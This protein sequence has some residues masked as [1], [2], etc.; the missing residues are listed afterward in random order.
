MN[1]K[2]IK[3]FSYEAPA[4]LIHEKIMHEAYNINKDEIFRKTPPNSRHVLPSILAS[5]IPTT[6][7]KPC[8]QTKE[9]RLNNTQFIT[10][11]RRCHRMQ[12]IK[13]NEELICKCGKTVDKYGDHIF[14][15][16]HHSKTKL[17]NHIRNTIHYLTQTIGIHGNFIKTKDSCKIEEGGL[18]PN[19]PS[20]RPGDI[21]IHENKLNT[22]QYTDFKE[23]IIAIDCTINEK[24][25][26]RMKHPND[27]KTATSNH[28]EHHLNIEAKKYNRPNQ[29]IGQ[30][31]ISGESIIHELNKQ[32]ITLKAFTI[33][34]FGTLGP[35]AESYFYNVKETKTIE[36][37][38]TI[39]KISIPARKANQKNKE[40]KI[41]KALFKKAN[42]GWHLTNKE[43]WFGSTYQTTVPSTWGNL[44][45]HVNINHAIIK[46]ISNALDKL[47]N[48]NKEETENKLYKIIGNQSLNH[49]NKNE[50]HYKKNKVKKKQNQ[51]NSKNHDDQSY[52][53]F[54]QVYDVSNIQKIPTYENTHSIPRKTGT[55][56]NS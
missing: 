42:E 14:S 13:T 7:L 37:E 56:L 29:K 45:L 46:H 35:Q 4:H 54:M 52:D 40:E 36:N 53:N 5:K 26:E 27:L 43:T 17:H 2:Q 33:D 32:N 47:S 24:M 51:K 6:L 39:K 34:Q 50:T 22:N 18:I 23:K 28:E 12:I 11:I 19:I 41:Y 20:I 16:T 9:N 30:R 21:T 31:H 49:E 8:R 44:Y 48:L 3:Q 1:K 15:C 38:Q 55:P 25:P 10:S